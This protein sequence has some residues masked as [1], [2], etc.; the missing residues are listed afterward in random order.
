M[1]QSVKQNKAIKNNSDTGGLFGHGK[2]PSNL[3]NTMLARSEEDFSSMY[4]SYQT[5]LEDPSIQGGSLVKPQQVLSRL[6]YGSFPSNTFEGFALEEGDDTFGRDRGQ[7]QMNSKE[8]QEHG[9]TLYHK[10][11][12]SHSLPQEKPL[13]SQQEHSALAK[14][15]ENYLTSAYEFS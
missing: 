13:N 3:S 14:G 1:N 12:Q 5:R 7:M 2:G 6:T 4:A 15:A 9:S 8:K 10:L 11:Q